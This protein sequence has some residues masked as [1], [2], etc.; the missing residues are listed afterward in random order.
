MATRPRKL[1]PTTLAA[2]FLLVV[3]ALLAGLAAG[4]HA[5]PVERDAFGNPLCLGELGYPGGEP[6]SDHRAHREC[7]DFGCQSP[8]AATPSPD[9]SPLPAAFSPSTSL[10]WTHSG[11]APHARPDRASI[12]LRGPPREI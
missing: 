6:A 12:R 1:S 5:A 7:C 11:R 2:A 3:H 10:V 8:A 9:R 4:A